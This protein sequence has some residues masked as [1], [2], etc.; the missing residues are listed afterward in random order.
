MLDARG[1]NVTYFRWR[2][3]DGRVFLFGR[4]LS[5]EEYDKATRI[6][7]GIENVVSVVNLAKI[8]AKD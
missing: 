3:V 2:S 7:E 8:R 5:T 4:A 1:V 6:A